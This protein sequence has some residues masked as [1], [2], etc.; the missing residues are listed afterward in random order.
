MSACVCTYACVCV[1]VT[2][3]TSA[4]ELDCARIRAKT[5]TSSHDSSSVPFYIDFIINQ[6]RDQTATAAK[7][8]NTCT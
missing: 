5:V 6:C 7:T 3:L 1:C 2:D 4:N 8:E